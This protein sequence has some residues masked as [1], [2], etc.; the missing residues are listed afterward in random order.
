MDLESFARREYHV[1]Q[2]AVVFYRKHPE[3]DE[4][5]DVRWIADWTDAVET[6]RGEPAAIMRVKALDAH[7]DGLLRALEGT[8][9]AMG[10]PAS[11]G[12]PRGP[13][14]GGQPD[15]LRA[16]RHRLLA[17]IFAV[18]R[19]RGRVDE[20]YRDVADRETV[21]A[22]QALLGGL[23][24]LEYVTAHSRE[25]AE[26]QRKLYRRWLGEGRR[27]PLAPGVSR[28]PRLRVI[29]GARLFGL[30]READR[31][32]QRTLREPRHVGWLLRYRRLRR[33]V[34]RLTF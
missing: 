24:K 32:L 34:K 28:A 30:A 19:T 27:P 18:E 6:L 10:E 29:L 9:E 33:L 7:T 2:M 26:L 8:L 4:I 17:L 15:P 16:A 13:A 11:P 3:L 5:L 23:L 21:A 22:A 20:W 14:R 12:V 25:L 31:A 1:G